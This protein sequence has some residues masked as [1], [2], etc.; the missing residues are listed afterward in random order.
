METR[1]TQLLNTLTKPGGLARVPADFC[2]RRVDRPRL[3]DRQSHDFSLTHRNHLH[4]VE[5]KD[6]EW[7]QRR[8]E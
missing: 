8:L 1:K 4:Y 5:E 6:A 3:N 7:V 2:A